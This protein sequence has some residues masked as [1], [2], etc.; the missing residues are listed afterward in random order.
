[1]PQGLQ[2]PLVS[3]AYEL[4]LQLPWQQTSAGSPQCWQ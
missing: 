3:Q 1:M 4:K 2:L